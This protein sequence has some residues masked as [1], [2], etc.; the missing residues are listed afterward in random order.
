MVTLTRHVE[1]QGATVKPVVPSFVA[2]GGS[3]PENYERHF[4]PAI[5]R[6]LAADLVAAGELAPGQRV[7]DVA[8]GTGIVARL[9]AHQVGPTGIVAGVDINP[10]MLAVARS[11]TPHGAAIHYREGR[12]ESLPFADSEFGTVFCQLGLQFFADK[13]A[14][15]Q[16]MRRVVAPDGCVLVSTT[17]PTPELFG[18]LAAALA[19]HV[20]PEAARF[21]DQVFS[22]DD[23]AHV[24]GL[25]RDAGF[26]NLSVE[27]KVRILHLPAPADF[28]WQYILST[29]L[30]TAVGPLDAGAR[31]GLERDVVSG[32]R[33]FAHDGGLMLELGV[34]LA[35]MR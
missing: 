21:V 27:R 31:A 1:T 25:F 5:G 7:L 15:L 30:A 9:A 4:I 12:A 8:C 6:P 20:S 16:E 23:P 10:G 18:V 14:A 33:T 29:P 11:V 17:G 32:W 28:L 34:L 2:H 26:S 35:T 19:R 22:L 3:A 24:R 13:I